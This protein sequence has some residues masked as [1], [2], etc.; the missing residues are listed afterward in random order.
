MRPF[1]AAAEEIAA[2]ALGGEVSALEL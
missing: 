1:H 2:D